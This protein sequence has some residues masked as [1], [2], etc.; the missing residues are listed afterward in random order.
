MRISKRTRAILGVAV[1]AIAVAGTGA[2]FAATSSPQSP[3]YQRPVTGYTASV[4]SIPVKMSSSGAGASAVVNAAG[5]LS[6]TPGSPASSTFAKADLVLPAGSV[7]PAAAPTFTPSAFGTGSPREVL[8]LANGDELMNNQ[9]SATVSDAADASAADWEVNLGKGWVN[10]L[11]TYAAAVA[12]V[13][14]AGQVVTDAY[15][16][17]DGDQAAGVTDVISAVQYGG[18]PLTVK[19][20]YAP[21][22]HLYGGHVIS[23]NNN[24][25]QIGWSDGPGVKYVL[26]RTF[27]YGFSPNGSPHLGFTGITVGYWRGLAAGHTYDIELIPAGAD[28]QPLPH[29]QVGWITIVTTR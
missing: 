17:A 18:Q 14:G 27:G 13:G 25:A 21:V 1:T 7:I 6:L 24:D 19:P 2:A 12:A 15:I 20:V 5:T 4:G 3:A 23:V 11:D 10:A 16:V 26:T 22:P 8:V 28:R 9:A 29:A